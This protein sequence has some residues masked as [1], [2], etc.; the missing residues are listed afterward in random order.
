M[1]ATPPKR[2]PRT[3]VVIGFV[4]LL[5]DFVSEMVV[6]L[7]PL[8]LVTVLAAGPVALGLIEGVA[9]TVSNL[10]KLWAGRRS[11]AQHR[12]RKPYVVAGYLLSNLVR[13]LIGI[14]GSW[15][16]VLAVRGDR[17][18]R[19][20]ACARRRVMRSFRMPFRTARPDTPTVSRARSTMPARYWAFAP[21]AV[22]VGYVAPRHRDCTLR[23][24]RSA[25]GAVGGI[26]RARSPAR[27]PGERGTCPLRWSAL[28]ETTR[29][30]PLVLVFFTLGKI[31]ETFY[32]CAGTRSAC[33]WSSC[34]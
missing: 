28:S 9:D 30:Y 21:A 8:L 20:R 3:V 15:L 27:G 4:S 17:P 22:V 19:Q 11:D 14:S 10:L 13:P 29:H 25:G 23:H 34:C 31:P 26:R 32:C 33:R 1:S 24:S 6:P 16:T 18:H 5:N 7:I 2:L 12:R